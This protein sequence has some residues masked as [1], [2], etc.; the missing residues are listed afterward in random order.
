M[1]TGIGDRLSLRTLFVLTAVTAIAVMLARIAITNSGNA[2]AKAAICAMA[3][4]LVIFTLFAIVYLAMLPFGI[5]A[6]IT[7]E[8]RK[9][10]ESP[11]A[12]DRPP[13]NQLPPSNPERAH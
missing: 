2:L 4:P 1:S 12:N 9:A 8:S 7:S 11:F 5:L 13:E 6:N 10:A 3:V